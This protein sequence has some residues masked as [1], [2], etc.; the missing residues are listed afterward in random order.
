M[1]E[2]QYRSRKEDLGYEWTEENSRA[3][4]MTDTWGNDSN[5]FPARKLCHSCG[6]VNVNV[7]SLSVSQEKGKK[8]KK[9]Q[10]KAGLQMT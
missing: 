8:V 10:G 1:S 7:I 3:R 9:V 4:Q 5:A 2:Q 6:Q